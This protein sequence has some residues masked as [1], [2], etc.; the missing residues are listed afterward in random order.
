MSA[1]LCPNA[2]FGP[3]STPRLSVLVPFFR[4]DPVPLLVMLEREARGL[5]GAVEIVVLHDGSGDATLAGRAQAQVAAMKTPALLIDLAVNEGRAKGRN[6]LAGQARADHLLFLDSD[7]APDAP[8]FLAR[9]LA[10]I[11]ADAPPVVFG[12]FSVP[13]A[14]PGGAFAFHIALALRGESAPAALR[15]LQPEKYVFT[16]NLLVRRD[17]F[18]AEAFD[19]GFSGWGWEDVEWGMRVARRFGLLHIDNPATHLGLDTAA[20]IAAKYESSTANF[21][22]ILARHP[23][24]IMAYP[25]YRLARVLRRTPFRK[26]WRGMLKAAALS[27]LPP[28]IARI[29]AMKVY[30]AA[31]YAEVV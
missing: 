16:S 21:A 29:A 24:V 12:G 3:A 14:R 2:A 22:R 25:S 30:R 13:D 4:D 20:A 10:L 8:D 9:Y 27:P 17:V 5:G 11:R 1:T 28:M 18:D 15:T 26:V 6:R 23:Q 7:M 31:L 19:E